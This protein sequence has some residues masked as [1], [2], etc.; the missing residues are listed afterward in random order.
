[1]HLNQRTA[2]VLYVA[3]MIACLVGVAFAQGGDT[4][5][6]DYGLTPPIWTIL[7]GFL[8]FVLHWY[9]EW[10]EGQHDLNF[11]AYMWTAPSKTVTAIVAWLAQMELVWKTA[12]ASLAEFSIG[13]II[14]ALNTGYVSDSAFNGTPKAPTQP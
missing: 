6:T 2:R 13:A 12:P 8:G 3:T 4:A 10:K 5:S 7:I 1:M 11:V 14:I 9:S